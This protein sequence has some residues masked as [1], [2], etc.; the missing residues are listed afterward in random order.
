MSYIGNSTPSVTSLGGDLDVN[1]HQIKST[2]NGNIEIVPDG[3]GTVTIDQLVMPTGT[4]SNGQA[5]VTDG[6]GNLSFSKALSASGK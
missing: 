5:L 3:S 1:G 6:S 2:S 4:G